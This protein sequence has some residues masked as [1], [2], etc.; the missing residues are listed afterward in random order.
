MSEKTSAIC[1][2]FDRVEA[3]IQDMSIHNYINMYLVLV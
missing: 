3:N 1:P 2:T